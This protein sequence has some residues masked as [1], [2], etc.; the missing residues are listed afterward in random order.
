[1]PQAV[2]RRHPEMLPAVQAQAETTSITGWRYVARFKLQ[3]T[4]ELSDDEREIIAGWYH[5]ASGESATDIGDNLFALLE[6]LGIPADS[7][8][9][10]M[11]NPDYFIKEAR[12]KVR[13]TI[14]AIRAYRLRHPDEEEVRRVNKSQPMSV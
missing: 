8:D 11:P 2:C 12:A 7:M 10:Y 5:S 14:A 6:K 3:M 13:E 9:L 1:M 4:I